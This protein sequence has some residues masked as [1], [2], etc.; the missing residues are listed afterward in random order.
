MKI[1][2]QTIDTIEITAK[3]KQILNSVMFY[4]E[5]KE[6][7]KICLMLGEIEFKRIC[8]GES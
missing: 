7:R 1:D 5:I 3:I 2:Y 4:F 8:F 6:S